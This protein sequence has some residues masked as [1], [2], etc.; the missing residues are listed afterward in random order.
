MKFIVFDCQ[1]FF[2]KENFQLKEMSM[3][4]SG[5]D[6]TYNFKPTKPFKQLSK[7]Q[8]KEVRYLEN[9]H[10]GIR[11][12]SGNELKSEELHTIIY[13][14]LKDV[15]RIYVKG[16]DKFDFI[17]NIVNSVFNYPPFI[18][19]IENCISSP[20]ITC[21]E[22]KNYC[23]NHSIEKFICSRHNAKVLYNSIVSFLP[24]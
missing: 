13:N 23:D 4:G 5:L 15:D 17:Y 3:Y 8:Q 2:H 19:N 21:I 24:Q 16:H 20:K 22:D 11:Y 14:S 7:K 12:S 9:Q 10:H 6:V 18:V 1:G